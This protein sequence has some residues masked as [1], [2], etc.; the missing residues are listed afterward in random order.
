LSIAALMPM[1]LG[2][3]SCRRAS[4]YATRDKIGD[5]WEFSAG[6]G[7]ATV[8]ALLKAAVPATMPI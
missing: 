5:T 6:P 8:D 2:C 7:R 4:S 3:C 1:L